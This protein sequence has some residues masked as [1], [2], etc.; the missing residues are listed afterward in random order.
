MDP[1]ARKETPYAFVEVTVTDSGRWGALQD[2]RDQ[3]RHSTYFYRKLGSLCV[4]RLQCVLPPLI[5]TR[6]VSSNCGFSRLTGGAQGSN[7]A[8]QQGSA[9]AHVQQPVRAHCVR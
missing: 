2:K 6:P 4:K 1:T 5:P 7:R 8:V 3:E 9:S